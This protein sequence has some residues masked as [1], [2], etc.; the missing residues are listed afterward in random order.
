MKF[1][2]FKTKKVREGEYDL[3]FLVLFSPVLQLLSTSRIPRNKKKIRKFK[4]DPEVSHITA[5]WGERGVNCEL[6]PPPL[7]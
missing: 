3:Q 4:W 7:L 6:P 5:Q 2:G 1:R